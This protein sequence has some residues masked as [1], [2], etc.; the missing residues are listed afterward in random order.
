MKLHSDIEITL[1]KIALT[2]VTRLNKAN[3]TMD[4][5]AHFYSQPTYAQRGGL[6]VYSGS[7][8]QRGGNVLGALKS[9]FLPILGNVAKRGVRSAFGLA[10]GVAKDAFAGKDIRSSL[11]NRGIAR[12]KKL[13]MHAFNEV[14]QGVQGSNIA[15]TPSRKRTRKTKAKQKAKR[16]RSNY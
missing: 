10:K 1:C 12:A 5:T 2:I 14:V 8:R 15:T 6:P 7:R 16:P 13:G 3:C 11:K 9:F 4:R